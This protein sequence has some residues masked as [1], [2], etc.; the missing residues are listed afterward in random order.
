MQKERDEKIW[1]TLIIVD[2]VL[3]VTT[4]DHPHSVFRHQASELKA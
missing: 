4:I 3:Y 1:V 2:Y